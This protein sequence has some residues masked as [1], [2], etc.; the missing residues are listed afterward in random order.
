MSTVPDPL[1]LVIVVNDNWPEPL[2]TRACPFVPSLVGNVQM[3]LPEDAPARNPKY[4]EPLASASEP[5]TK[6][7]IPIPMPPSV[8]IEPVNVDVAFVAVFIVN[9]EAEIPAIKNPF[10]FLNT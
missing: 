5:P 3:K 8:I 6:A 10:V 1:P 2:V 4:W 7:V 9:E